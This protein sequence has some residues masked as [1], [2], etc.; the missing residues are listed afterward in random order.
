[1]VESIKTVIV[2]GSSR[3]IGRAIAYAFANAGHN[4]V[5]NGRKE[6]SE[7]QLSELSHFGGEIFTCIGDISDPDFASRLIKETK[8]KFGSVDV[9]INNAGITRDNLLLRMTEEEFDQTIDINLKGTFYT[10]KVASKYM[11]KQKSG[12][13]INLA[14]VVGQV[15]NAGQANYAASK[16]GIIGFTKSVARELAPRGITVN[17]IAPGFVDSDMTDVL[18]DKVKET[19]L[20]Q[21]PLKRLGQPE[22][23][24]EAALFLSNQ[25]YITGQVINVDGGM[26][27]NG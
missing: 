26:V 22:E 13:I 9:L 8:D 20:T 11:L 18:S 27:M 21:I 19:I 10:T 25:K 2:T 23:V 14:S 6:I 16:A 7:E 3:G 17:A 4:V 24:A 15:G 5:L 12:C 1:M